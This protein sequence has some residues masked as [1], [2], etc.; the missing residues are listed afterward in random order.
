VVS[1]TP[2]P[3]Q[4]HTPS[5]RIHDDMSPITRST[6]RMPKAMQV[7][8][9]TKSPKSR[10]TTRGDWISALPTMHVLS[11][12]RYVNRGSMVV[13]HLCYI[14]KRFLVLRN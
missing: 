11:S 7:S 4:D 1:S 6:R 2:A 8:R 10:H 3:R 13:V 14:C 12:Y 5:P 9:S